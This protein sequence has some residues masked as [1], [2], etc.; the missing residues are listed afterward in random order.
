MQKDDEILCDTVKVLHHV[1]MVFKMYNVCVL[2]IFKDCR[3]IRDLVHFIHF[4]TAFVQDQFNLFSAKPAYFRFKYV[5]GCFCYYEKMVESFKK[6]VAS[7]LL[8]F[9]ATFSVMFHR[10]HCVILWKITV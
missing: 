8:N 4:C 1:S 2:T 10:S 5:Y 3:F 6:C 9:T 7:N